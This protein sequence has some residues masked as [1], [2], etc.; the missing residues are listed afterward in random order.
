MANVTQHI[1]GIVIIGRSFSSLPSPESVLHLSF[2]V[3]VDSKGPMRIYG[4]ETL[5]KA[6]RLYFIRVGFMSDLDVKICIFSNNAISSYLSFQSLSNDYERAFEY[7]M[8][9]LGRLKPS[10]DTHRAYMQEMCQGRSKVYALYPEDYYEFSDLFWNKFAH[11]VSGYDDRFQTVYKVVVLAVMTGQY[12]SLL[13][14]ERYRRLYHKLRLEDLEEVR[15][16]HAG[17][18]GVSFILIICKHN[19]KV[20]LVVSEVKLYVNCTDVGKPESPSTYSAGNFEYSQG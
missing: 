13:E 10:S 8:K 6:R 19:L 5:N 9:A 14:D 1:D 2:P 15:Y 12:S 17:Y 11:V 4:C 16:Y 20:R 3:W 18:E 7:A